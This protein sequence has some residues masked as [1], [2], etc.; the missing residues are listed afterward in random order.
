V[1]LLR[2]RVISAVALAILV[3]VPT[4]LGGLPFLVLVSLAGGLAAWEYV[5]LLRQEGDHPILP[6]CVLVT[7]LFIAQGYWTAA[8]PL[9]LALAAA[10]AG[11]LRVT[12]WHDQSKPVTDWALTLAGALY[13]GVLLSHAVLLRNLVDGLAW[14]LVGALTVFAADTGAYF[15][16]RAFGRHH[17]WPRHSPKKTW[18][19][20]IGGAAAAATAAALLGAWLLDLSVWEGLALGLLLGLAAP[21]GD[22]AESMIKRQVGAKDS[23]HLIPGHGGILDR[24]DSL[25]IGL[26]IVY[27]WAVLFPHGTA[28]PQ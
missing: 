27:Y 25:L 13:L 10:V 23:S 16:G 11:S 18:E 22:L 24:I 20:F 21:L 3:A 8:I 4:A 14:L 1:T 12:L 6:L 9:R 19:G 26:P 2:T 28:W 17:W 5:N 15:A 7:L